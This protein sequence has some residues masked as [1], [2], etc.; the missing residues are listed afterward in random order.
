MCGCVQGFVEIYPQG[1]VPIIVVGACKCGFGGVMNGYRK[2]VC[3][4]N[5][6]AVY[7]GDCAL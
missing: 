3:G 2:T 7:I 1:A 5:R 4:S 6:V